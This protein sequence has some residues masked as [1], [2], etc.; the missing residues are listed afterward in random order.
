MPFPPDRGPSEGRA[1][2]ANALVPGLPTDA[3]SRKAL[4]V[5]H[6]AVTMLLAV[7]TRDCLLEPVL[8]WQKAA[9]TR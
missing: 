6:P 1:V 4:K 7:M 2:A 5:R 8:P 9:V 3:S